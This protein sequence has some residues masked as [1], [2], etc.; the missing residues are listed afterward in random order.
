M[1]N[2]KQWFPILPLVLTV[3]LWVTGCSNSTAPIDRS[4]ASDVP[5]GTVTVVIDFGDKT[6]EREIE[7]VPAGT[8]VAQV[9]AEI[10][11]PPVEM[12]GSGAM[13][14]V[15]SIG[16][17]GLAGGKGW[18]FSV[19]GQRSNQGVGS[20][21]LSPPARVEWTHSSQRQPAPEAATEPVASSAESAEVADE[22][23]EHATDAP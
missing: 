15:K 1:Q 16:E 3:S 13:T 22:S 5:T 12:T 6:V 2:I 7:A 17:L 9:M 11:D 23:A 18:T 4:G 20:Y 8:T 21:V 14:F 10:T 19:D